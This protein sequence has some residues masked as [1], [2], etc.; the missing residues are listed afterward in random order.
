ML[1]LNDIT[2]LNAAMGTVAAVSTA[3]GGY[4]TYRYWKLL[5]ECEERK[6]RDELLPDTRAQLVQQWVNTARSAEKS[7]VA[8]SHT[9]GAGE[10][11][12]DEEQR[13]WDEYLDVLT[14]KCKFKG[15]DVKIL[16]P[17]GVDR[18]KSLYWRSRAGAK[19]KVRR[20]INYDVRFQI[21]DE[22]V[23][24]LNAQ[25]R[26]VNADV[27]A[28]SEA[29][30]VLYA[31]G[32]IKHFVKMF[33]EEWCDED[34]K[35]FDDSVDEEILK[36][37]PSNRNSSTSLTFGLLREQLSFPRELL[38]ARLKALRKA[39]KVVIITCGKNEYITRN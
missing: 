37:V 11:S 21:C 10:G 27:D 33:D 35:D 30:I 6:K 20:N 24:V 26:K 17:M 39:N 13:L 36:Y 19:V 34:S 28:R 16:G 23:M 22:E 15:T 31:R 18:A 38:A 2:I 8:I 12:T 32:V 3:V 1:E 29:G 9:V 25:E 7:I 4:S 5:E 14:E